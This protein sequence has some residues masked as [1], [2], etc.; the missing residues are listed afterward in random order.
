MIANF[1]PLRQSPGSNSC[2]P[3]TVRAVLRWQGYLASEDEVSEWCRESILGCLWSEAL[4]GLAEAGFTID[5]LRGEI[6]AVEDDLGAL[7]T[8]VEDTEDPQ[9]VIVTVQEPFRD[10]NGDHAVVV[11]GFAP[12]IEDGNEREIVIYM[13]PLS[14][15]LEQDTADHFGQCWS[16]AD[17]R[18]FTITV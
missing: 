7:R 14:G 13:E 12:S 18:A 5:E 1:T 11:I 16:Q 2:L 9:P 15:T 3:T 10:F 8:I 6:R 17:N 4:D